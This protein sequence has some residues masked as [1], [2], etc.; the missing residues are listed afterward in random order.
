M[1]IKTINKW[2]TGGV[3]SV[4]VM[5]SAGAFVLSFDVLRREAIE[6]GVNAQLAWI[7]PLIV[8]TSIIGG[9]MFVI[10]AS[11]NRRVGLVRLGY[12][13]IVIVTALS[14]ALNRYHA[15]ADKLL[16]IIYMVAPPLL[17][18]TMTML[19]ERMLEV[20]LSDV[21]QENSLQTLV[22]SLKAT[23][24]ELRQALQVEQ[25]TRKQL[26][27]DYNRVADMIPLLAYVNPDV[28]LFAKARAGLITMDDALASQATYNRR[29][30]AE[31]FAER[32][33]ISG[34]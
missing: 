15:T 18:A 5:L 27:T 4:L 31:A 9:S 6:H 34:D 21:E 26:E 3:I 11:I 33:T 20:V 17:L 7:F 14:V 12:G 16:N 32:V 10:W 30:Q 22:A 23:V 24:T 19:V 13:V 25:A 8:D 28:F 29:N 1:T 2:A